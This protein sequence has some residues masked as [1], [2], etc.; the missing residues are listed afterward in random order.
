MAGACASAG[1]F[2]A[3]DSAV[4]SAA[5]AEAAGCCCCDSR[6]A[7]LACPRLAAARAADGLPRADACAAA[8]EQH[9]M[10]W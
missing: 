7:R 6:L 1:C 8:Q 4:A 2:E 5:W 9:V 10:P 3:E